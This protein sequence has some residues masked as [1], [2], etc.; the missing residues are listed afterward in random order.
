MKLCPPA[1]ICTRFYSDLCVDF[2][3]QLGASF[4]AYKPLDYS[5]LPALIH[6]CLDARR[7][8]PAAPADAEGLPDARR[9]A[10]VREKLTELGIPLL[11]SG[12]LCLTEAIALL[13][14]ANDRLLM[15][16]LSKGLYVQVAERVRSTPA[17][18]ERAV[19]T[20]ISVGFDR[21]ALGRCFNR[22]PSNREFIQYLYD[23]VKGAE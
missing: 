17:R 23:A 13:T 4:V 10:I 6:A 11:L 15:R 12:A 1:I 22:R 14:P 16:N 21:G 8:S 2:A 7:H 18:V 3:C 5:R 20:A 9:A 19:R